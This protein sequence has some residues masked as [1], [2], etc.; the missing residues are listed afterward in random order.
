M[1]DDFKEEITDTPEIPAAANIFNVRDDNKRELLDKTWAQAFHNA[2]AQLL[3]NRVQCRKDSQMAIAFLTTRVRKL[4]K[5]D[6]NK[7]RRLLGYLKLTIKLTLI[8]RANR[9]NVIKWWVDALYV[10]HD[11]MWGETGETMLMGKD[12]F[13]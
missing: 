9:L 2:V 11:N 3:F 5:D 4:D 10:A 7:L 6:W 13:R 8:L 12:G 1:L